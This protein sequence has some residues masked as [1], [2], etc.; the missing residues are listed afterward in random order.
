MPKILLFDD[1]PEFA[2]LMR[3]AY[4]AVGFDV[5]HLPAPPDDMVEFVV[6]E[7]PDLIHCDVN[8]PNIDGFDAMKLLVADPR[9]QHVPFF[10]VSALSQSEFVKS[11]LALGALRYFVKSDIS[12]PELAQWA[13][14]QL[15]PHASA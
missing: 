2:A 3:P 13:K 11:G 9:T 12:M 5:V 1:D 6:R 14:S 10:F 4:E 15:D 7:Q 8:M